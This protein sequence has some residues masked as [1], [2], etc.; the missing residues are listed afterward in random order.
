MSTVVRLL[1]PERT[2]NVMELPY[3]Q[4][5][6]HQYIPVVVTRSTAYGLHR[7]KELLT[8]WHPGVPRPWL[9]VVR[10]APLPTPG[11]ARYRLR[12]LSGR[13]LGVAHVPYLHRLRLVDDAAEALTD[14]AV[15][16][17]SRA[18][19]ASLGLTD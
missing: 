9:V 1:D 8:A 11:P 17:A 6:P 12:A 10:D 18:L 15:S 16:R 14:R 7:T 5:L 2:G 19:R 3:G 13:T 4:H